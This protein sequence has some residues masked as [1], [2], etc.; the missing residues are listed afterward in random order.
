MPTKHTQPHSDG[1]SVYWH[2]TVKLTLWL[3]S[4][5]LLTSIASLLLAEMPEDWVL[6]GWPMGYAIVA[7]AAPLIYLLIIGVY[8][9]CMSRNDRDNVSAQHR[10]QQ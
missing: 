3:S 8:S 5:W 4:I 7:F 9:W 6:F 2:K 10:S 1:Y